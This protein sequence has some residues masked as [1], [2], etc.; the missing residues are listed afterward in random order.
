M[1]AAHHIQITRIPAVMTHSLRGRVLRPGL[2][3]TE[4]IFDCDAWPETFH[5]GARWTD[6]PSEAG[7]LVGIATYFPET[8]PFWQA[9]RPF[10]LRGMAVD[11]QWRRHRIGQTLLQIGEEELGKL[12]CDLLWFNAR[13]NAF[14]F[15]RA[16]GYL[17]QGELFEIPGVGPHKVMMK[18]F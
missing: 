12:D 10:R 14:D 4:S 16:C 18:R 6:Y 1:S 15:Y 13:E 5:L 17:E 2:P 3:P 8:H 7:S 11:P 9:Q